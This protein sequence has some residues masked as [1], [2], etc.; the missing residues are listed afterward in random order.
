M[1]TPQYK[2][3]ADKNLFI[4][5][6]G[7]SAGSLDFIKEFFLS[8]PSNTDNLTLILAQHRSAEYTTHIHEIIK[9]N[10]PWTMEIIE[11]SVVPQAGH[12]YINPS[13]DDLWMQ[14]GRLHLQPI[15][16]STTATPSIDRL[17]ES[18][19]NEVKSKCIGVI[20]SGTGSDGTLGAKHIKKR[21]GHVIVQAPEEA[22]FTPMPESVIEAGYADVVLSVSHMIAEIKSYIQNVNTVSN[23][24]SELEDFNDVL[25]MLSLNFGTDFSS[26]KSNTIRRRL[27]K[28]MDHLNIEGTKDYYHYLQSHPGEVS[29]LFDT[30]L[31][32][33]TEFFRNPQAFKDLKE[34]L[35]KMIDK[36]KAGD[37]IRIWSVGCSTGEEPFSIAILLYEILGD[38]VDQYSIQIFATDVDQRAIAVARKGIYSKDHLSNV[39]NDLVRKY[40]YENSGQYELKKVIRQHVLFSKHDITKDPPFV[41]LDVVTCRNLLIYFDTNLQREVIPVFHYALNAEGLLFLGKSENISSMN[42]LFTNLESRSRIFQKDSSAEINNLR[43]SSFRQKSE[44]TKATPVF[45][46]ITLEENIAKTLSETFEYPYVI[47]GEDMQTLLI[48]GSLQPYLELSEGSLNSNILK[49]INPAIHAELRT[50]FNRI[51]KDKE[52]CESSIIN[53]EVRGEQELLKLVMKPLMYT[54]NGKQNYIVIFKKVEKSD[55]FNIPEKMMERDEASHIIRIMELEQELEATREH[56]KAFTEEL[57][58]GNEELQAVN[59]ELQSANEELKSSNEELETSNE[60]LQSANEEL[61]TANSELNM[62]HQMMISKEHQLIAAKEEL[63]ITKDRF[64]TALNNS[65]IFI[66]YQDKGLR[67]YWINNSSERFDATRIIGKSDEDLLGKE[68]HEVSELKRKVLITAE[69]VN[70]EVEY[71]GNFWDVTCKPIVNDGEVTG[72]KTIAVDISAQKNALKEQKRS[73]EIINTLMDNL[74][75]MMFVVDTD[76][77]IIATNRAQKLYFEQIYDVIA[78][79]GDNYKT[80]FKDKPKAIERV[81]KLMKPILNGEKI[82]IE[83]LKIEDVSSDGSPLYFQIQGFPIKSE[84]GTVEGGIIVS[85]NITAK[86]KAE[87]Q[88]EYIIRHAS[89]L[90]NEEFFHDVINHLYSLFGAKHIFFAEVD[91]EQN[92]ASVRAYRKSGQKASNFDF[93]LENSPTEIVFKENELKEFT[94][95]KNEFPDDPILKQWKVEGYIGIPVTSPTTGDFLGVF[96][97]AHTEPIRRITNGDY[98]FKIVALRA[99]AEIE[100]NKNIQELQKR[101]KQL[102]NITGNLPEMIYEYVS[103]DDIYGDHF[104]FVSHAANNIYEIQPEHMLRNS[105][106]AW[107]AIY[108][109]DFEEFVVKME[110]SSQKLTTFNWTGRIIGNQSYKLRWVKLTAKPERI[111]DKTI[112]WYG[113][114]TDISRMKQMEKDLEHAKNEAEK[115]A[116]AKEDFLA[117]M[118]HEIRTPL[119]GIMGI[120]EL[121]IEDASD[122]DMEYLGVLKFSAD[123]LLNLIN[124]ILDFSKIEAGEVEVI[125]SPIVLPHLIKNLEYSHNFKARENN[126]EFLVK[127]DE[128]LPEVVHGDEMI[129]LQILNN[130]LGNANKFTKQGQVTLDVESLG[131]T[132]SYDEIKF[133][134]SDTGVG[135]AEDDIDRIFERFQQLG[136]KDQRKGGTGL[137]L[138]IVKQLLEVLQSELHIES[139]VGKGSKFYFTIKFNKASDDSEP[140]HPKLLEEQPGEKVKVLVAEDMSDHRELIKKYMSKFNAYTVEFAVDGIEVIEKLKQ[141]DFDIIIMDLRM[142]K[143]D[144]RHAAA[145]IRSWVGDKYQNIPIIALTSDLM[146]IKKEAHFNDLILKP[147]SSKDLYAKLEKYRS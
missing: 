9:V 107:E 3:P 24:P 79:K 1:N 37:S 36:K 92:K 137:G 28:R 78:R 76:L 67:Y 55:R 82:T 131:S 31:I 88:I 74:Q 146:D 75:D 4:I 21:N 11:E 18:L 64:E 102:Q 34:N 61:Q 123:N 122:H 44:R 52:N 12:I 86:I 77:N 134:V 142:P 116:A 29:E 144:G 126:N 48:K 104:T 133:V 135:I 138:G 103:T 136:G 108:E 43:F 115:L 30:M 20:L 113:I 50:C 106:L 87:E 95:I 80:L 39:P 90:S 17:F 22:K 111:D 147:I 57:E 143:I 105:Q 112:K 40:F 120:T 72:V 25:K 83:K 65:D 19:A 33:V 71:G 109:D 70:Q 13:G 32:G 7:A 45:Q 84:E 73:Y 145:V 96:V 121:M 89:N 60:E 110:E 114:I 38:K 49:I 10:K 94:D 46:E 101:E 100:T 15:S 23:N 14:D 5:G 98:L 139:T 85:S 54:H 91:T 51:K 56:L 41:K 132:K 26:Y 35:E 130:L 118:S 141:E 6:I 124:N 81:N 119:N 140:N 62:T 128:D 129:L 127:M 125:E 68:G 47:L 53:F 99:G 59:E 2:T 69:D 58:V 27:T 42:D 117:V 66:G 93:Q 16:D 8:L 97:M 63:E